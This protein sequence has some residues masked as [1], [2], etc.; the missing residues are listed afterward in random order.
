MHKI[1]ENNVND[2]DT[3]T[4]SKILIALVEKQTNIC[5]HFLTI[6]SFCFFSKTQVKSTIIKANDKYS[7]KYVKTQEDNNILFSIL[8]K[9]VTSNFAAAKA[10]IC[11]SS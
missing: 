4:F 6:F 7:I 1:K 5:G 11:D 8:K 2:V 3:L 9:Q 10:P